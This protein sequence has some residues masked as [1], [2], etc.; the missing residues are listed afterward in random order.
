MSALIPPVAPSCNAAERRYP[1]HHTLGWRA[2]RDFFENDESTD[3]HRS[4]LIKPKTTPKRLKKKTL[5]RCHDPFAGFAWVYGFSLIS[6][7]LC[8]SVDSTAYL[9]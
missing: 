7:Y 4:T 5:L 6:V 1:S 9:P 3:E 2:R 8:S